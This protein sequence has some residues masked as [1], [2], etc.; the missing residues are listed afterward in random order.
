M[1]EC[2]CAFCKEPVAVVH[3]IFPRSMGGKNHIHNLI[4]LC[5][6]CHYMIHQRLNKYI[7][8]AVASSIRMAKNE[9]E[10]SWPKN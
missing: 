2:S 8:D 1:S 6:R 10:S 7:V 9:G 4:G 3:H 5:D